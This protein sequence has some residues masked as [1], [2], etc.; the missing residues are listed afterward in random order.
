MPRKCGALSSAPGRKT[1]TKIQFFNGV[2]T[3]YVFNIHI[4]LE[5]RPRGQAAVQQKAFITT[6]SS[7]GQHQE[8]LLLL[9]SWFILASLVIA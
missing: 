7:T 1:K 9:E 8:K 2:V 3:F 4:W 6:V 5:K